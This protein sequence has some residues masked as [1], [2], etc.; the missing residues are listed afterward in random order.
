MTANPGTSW[1]FCKLQWA[2]DDSF[3]SKNPSDISNLKDSKGVIQNSS[4]GLIKENLVTIRDCRWF[5]R[6]SFTIPQQPYLSRVRANAVISR[7]AQLPSLDKQLLIASAGRSVQSCQRFSGESIT[8]INR[9]GLAQATIHTCGISYDS[10]QV[11]P[12][13]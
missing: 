2:K 13:I 7:F 10:L 11:K 3:K 8:E 6:K 5:C 1:G 9:T 4:F 12:F